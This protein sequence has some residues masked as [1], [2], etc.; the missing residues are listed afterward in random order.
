MK[1]RLSIT[2]KTIL[3]LTVA[4]ALELV[5]CAAVLIAAQRGRSAR[6][7][8]LASAHQN[9]SML[10]NEA[11]QLTDLR[12]QY[13]QSRQ[14]LKRLEPPMAPNKGDRMVPSIMIEMSELA[15]KTGVTLTALRPD[16]AKAPATQP[17]GG[18]GSSQGATKYETRRVSLDMQGTFAQ[19]HAFLEGLV[20]FPKPVE[21][22]NVQLRPTVN[23]GSGTAPSLGVSLELLCYMI[24]AEDKKGEAARG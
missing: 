11:N 6:A 18:A 9:L 24:Y 8:E 16:E 13:L 14:L 10:R 19:V 22:S 12:L 20:G 3:V 7:A 21:I 4:L 5:A 15:A 23:R 1:A 17:S 2:K